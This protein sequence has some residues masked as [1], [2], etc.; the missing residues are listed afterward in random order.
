MFE[1]L[2]NTSRAVFMSYLSMRLMLAFLLFIIL[3]LGCVF[4]YTNM[5][6]GD[7]M[8]KQVQA[9]N[10]RSLNQAA[11]LFYYK[12]D[13]ITGLLA[14]QLNTEQLYSIMSESYP[15]DP[16]R[17]MADASVI[18]QKIAIL[19]NNADTAAVL[20]YMDSKNEILGYSNKFH[21]LKEGR[22]L[23][24]GWH[25]DEQ[26]LSLVRKIYNPADY[27]KVI[28][29]I[30]I[31]L[32][33]SPF[34]DI[35]RN[36]QI[37]PGSI[38]YLTD[39]GGQAVLAAPE[40]AAA[41]L[42][43]AVQPMLLSDIHPRNIP[44]DELNTEKLDIGGRAVWM[45]SLRI[46][47]PYWYSPDWKLVS[48]TPL[49]D[50]RKP[51]DKAIYGVLTVAVS[52]AVVFY[53]FSCIFSFSVLEELKGNMVKARKMELM[54][55][56]SQINP[57][58]LYNTLDMINWSAVMRNAPE[59]SQTVQALSRF[60]KLSLNKGREFVLLTDELSHVS[61]YMQ[62]QNLRFDGVF[63][64]YQEASE[65]AKACLVLKT[66]LQPLAENAIQHGILEK[67]KREGEIRVNAWVEN[68]DLFITVFDNG[69]G[70][71]PGKIDKILE[72]GGESDGYGL[73]NV[74]QRL[75]LAYG[76]AYGLSFE[77]KPGCFTKAI[78]KLPVKK[79]EL[80]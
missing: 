35:L 17:Q 57:H 7:Q 39:S 16:I 12:L 40:T 1:R 18:L 48:L 49:E 79:L 19:E 47:H 32:N 66:I 31:R 77:S 43:I 70:I 72:H 67:A 56:Q 73:Y 25:I 8:L 54:V 9:Y 2:R 37:T 74:H 4:L 42:S 51:I 59:I 22:G 6:V 41:G 14:S 55:M 63:D 29:I 68:K 21:E 45:T 5:A 71:D 75:R 27:S 28:G 30:Q 10:E 52:S 36:I 26:G 61:V 46:R 20:V 33:K 13:K 3:P 53:G 76:L 34:W 65:E 11:D 15:A 69:V 44:L 24:S 78:L 64:F 50:V 38:A 80:H 60:Y 62:I 23:T 58:F